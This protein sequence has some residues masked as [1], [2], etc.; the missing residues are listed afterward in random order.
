MGGFLV[1]CQKE[2]ADHLGSKR[3]LLLFGLI[4]ILAVVAAYQGATSLR[5]SQT[6]VFINIFS[7][8]YGGGFS[9]TYIMYIFGPIIGLSLGFDAI[10]R[11]RTQGTLSVLLSQPIFRDSI[12]NGK[13]LAGIC[14]LSLLV[15]ST[16]GIM[17]GVAIPLLGFGPGPEETVRIVFFTVI[18]MLYFSVWLALGILFSV[19]TKKT[20]T[21]MLLS[22]SSWL[23][24]VFLITLLTSVIVNFIV[25]IQSISGFNQNQMNDYMTRM[26]QRSEMYETIQKVSPSILYQEAATSI[27]TVSTSTFSSGY[28]VTFGSPTA[29]QDIFATWPQMTV[30]AVILI[31]C[32]AASY[33]IFLRQEIRAGN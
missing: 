13:F 1:I 11:E 31:I 29:Q 20:T 4:M 33:I 24:S 17:T 18:T 16:I 23:L 14:A 26:Q 19:I 32:F 10:N 3:F 22:V 2:L 25:P 6:A 27:T 28:V 9:F 8:Y 5:D 12:I 15:V 21:S 30:L 7:G